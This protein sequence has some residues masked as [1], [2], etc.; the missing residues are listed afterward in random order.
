MDVQETV[1]GALN[2]WIQTNPDCLLLFAIVC[3][4]CGVCFHLYRRVNHVSDMRVAD[5]QAL[6]TVLQQ[7]AETNA[8][9]TVLIENYVRR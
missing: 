9:L 3:V 7:S 6:A 4:L 1:T 8:R 5:A 2:S